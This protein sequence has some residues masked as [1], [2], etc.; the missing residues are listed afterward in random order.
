MKVEETT[1]RKLTITEI[2]NLDPIS[3][4]IEEYEVGQAKVIIQ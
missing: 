2:P 1:V 4:I 3:V